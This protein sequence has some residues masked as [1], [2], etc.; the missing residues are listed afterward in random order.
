MGLLAVNPLIKET[1]EEIDDLRRIENPDPTVKQK[2][3]ELIFKLKELEDDK[4]KILRGDLGEAY[5][6]A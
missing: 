1:Q 2:L 6:D 4:A 5:T 3:A